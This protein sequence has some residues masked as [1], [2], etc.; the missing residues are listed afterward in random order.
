MMAPHVL[1]SRRSLQR[2]NI[3]RKYNIKTNSQTLE[4]QPYQFGNLIKVMVAHIHLVLSNELV[5]PLIQVDGVGNV[6]FLPMSHRWYAE[7][8][9]VKIRHVRDRRVP[10]VEGP[11]VVNKCSGSFLIRSRRI[12]RRLGPLHWLDIRT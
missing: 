12:L 5:G 6:V 7:V 10:L 11:P 2:E 1:E 9:R 3:R 4:V 8:V